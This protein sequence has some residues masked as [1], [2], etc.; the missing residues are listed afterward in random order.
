MFEVGLGLSGVLAEGAEVLLGGNYLSG[1]PERPR[2]T[3]NNR[4]IYIYMY[5]YRAPRSFWVATTC[6][7]LL[8]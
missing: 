2:P 1:T 6:L 7:I 5:I 4:H 8:V 3:S